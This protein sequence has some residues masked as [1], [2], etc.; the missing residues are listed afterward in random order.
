M[1][2]KEKGVSL[3]TISEMYNSG[4]LFFNLKNRFM[5]SMDYMK[6]KEVYCDIV[7]SDFIIEHI[8]NQ[9]LFDTQNHPN[10]IV[11]AFVANKILSILGIEFEYDIFKEKPYHIQGLYGI[12][13]SMIKE[14]DLTYE[15]PY[16]GEYASHIGNI[17]NGQN[18]PMAYDVEVLGEPTE[19]N[20]EN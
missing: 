16:H 11:L 19:I 15:E 17:Y 2:L 1:E 18:K 8:R 10:G 7:V 14:L 12:S 5:K 6:R 3:G 4:E 13:A 20:A 9:R